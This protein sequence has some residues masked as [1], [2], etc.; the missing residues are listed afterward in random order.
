MKIKSFIILFS[1]FVFFLFSS[2]EKSKTKVETSA[3]SENLKQ[4]QVSVASQNIKANPKSDVAM[5]QE[6]QM[7]PSYA[8]LPANTK[9]LDEL[10]LVYQKSLVPSAKPMPKPGS[11]DYVTITE[12]FS[13]TCN[14]CNEFRTDLEK[15]KKTFGDKLKVTHYPIGWAGP[16]PGRMYYIAKEKSEEIANKVKHSIFDAYFYSGVNI[17]DSQILGFIAE[18]YGLNQ[19]LV[20]KLKDEKIVQKMEIAQDYVR[21]FNIRSTPT[22]LIEDSFTVTR[23]PTNLKKVINAFLKEPVK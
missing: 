16:N 14:H 6:N 3:I 13:F 4:E 5:N 18:E 7:H 17:N 15:L 1:L 21:K 8:S 20:E 23:D 9:T 12:V 22:I 11:L 19:N 10:R 2:C